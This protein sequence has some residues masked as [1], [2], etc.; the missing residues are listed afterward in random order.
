[1]SGC[2]SKESKS[3]KS[4]GSMSTSV[5]G[6]IC[7]ACSTEARTRSTSM[8]GKSPP[9]WCK[10]RSPKPSEPSKA[11]G[12][13]SRQPQRQASESLHTFCWP[14]V[15]VVHVRSTSRGRWPGALRPH[16]QPPAHPTSTHTLL[17]LIP[18]VAELAGDD[19][20][21]AVVAEFGDF[22]GLEGVPGRQSL[23]RLA[24]PARF[25]TC[26]LG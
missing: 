20:V 26:L 5:A 21:A 6:G 25:L 1:M 3:L 12:S 10:L 16:R 7:V 11:L 9:T 8:G 18:R 4:G 2:S 14:S 19:D 17:I 15:A 13:P 23:S 22:I 24:V